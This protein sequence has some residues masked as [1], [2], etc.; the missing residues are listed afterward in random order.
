MEFT[1]RNLD[2]ALACKAKLNELIENP[3]E[4]VSEDAAWIVA[5]LFPLLDNAPRRYLGQ[6]LLDHSEDRGEL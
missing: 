2:Q 6:W 5:N 3:P 1:F 4:D